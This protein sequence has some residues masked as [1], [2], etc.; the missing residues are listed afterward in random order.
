MRVNVF[1]TREDGQFLNKLLVLP[2]SVQSVIPEQFRGA[3]DY[4]ATVDSGDGMFGDVDAVTVEAAIAT[5]GFAVVT[6]KV[7][8]RR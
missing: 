3:W 4:Y 7:E 5:S 6:P 2:A 8:D 1:I